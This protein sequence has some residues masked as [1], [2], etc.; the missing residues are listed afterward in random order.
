M[1]VEIYQNMRVEDE[2]RM[3]SLPSVWT[4]SGETKIV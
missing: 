2:V 1:V 3:Y 4:W